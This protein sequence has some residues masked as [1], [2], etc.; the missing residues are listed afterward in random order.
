MSVPSTADT[1]KE[2]LVSDFSFEDSTPPINGTIYLINDRAER[3]INDLK[4]D[5]TEAGSE[6][7]HALNMAELRLKN[8]RDKIRELMLHLTKHE[9]EVL[10]E[11]ERIRKMQQI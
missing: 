5:R 8:Q 3:F 4:I 6:L 7:A 9:E 10:L 2:L 1:T 11:L